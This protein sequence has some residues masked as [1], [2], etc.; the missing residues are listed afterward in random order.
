[1]KYYWHCIE[2]PQDLTDKKVQA[3]LSGKV[4]DLNGKSIVGAIIGVEKLDYNYTPCRTTDLGYTISKCN[5]AYCIC[6]P[7]RCGVDYKLC[8][9]PPLLRDRCT[10]KPLRDE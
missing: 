7:K 6:L 9:W 3:I 8:I 2:I 1:M 10:M 5:G 4:V